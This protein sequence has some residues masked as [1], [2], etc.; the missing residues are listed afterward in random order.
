M[1]EGMTRRE[2]LGA[3]A[4]GAIGLAAGSRLIGSALA[5][6]GELPYWTASKTRVGKVY[7]GGRGGWPSPT[8]DPKDD[9]KWIEG[10]LAKLDP[11][12]ADIE[13]VDGGHVMNPADMAAAKEKFKDVDGILLIPLTMFIMGY[14]KDFLSLDIPTIFFTVPYMGH[15][16]TTFA[17][18]QKQ[19]KRVELLA[20]SDFNAL[21]PAMRPFR[22]IHHLKQA[23]ILDFRNGG[24]LTEYAEGIK[25]RFGTE[26]QFVPR[27]RL[28]EAYKAVDEKLA[29]A[30]A[31][32][33]TKEAEKIVEPTEDDILRGSRLYFAMKKILEEEKA[34]LITIQYCMG[35][36]DLAGAYPCLGFSRLNAE[37]LGG[38]CEGD[39]PSSVT[40]LVFQ[41]LT[42]ERKPGFISDPII[43]TSKGTVIH[44]HCT[45]AVKMDGP[46]G[47]QCPYI[48]R[49]QQEGQRGACLQVKMRVGQEI[50]MAK[51]VD[52]HTMLVSPGEITEIPDVDRACRTKLTTKVKDAQKM[53]DNWHY[54]LHRVVFY[55]DHVDD[56]RRLSRFLGFKV[57]EEGVDEVHPPAEWI[58]RD[59]NIYASYPI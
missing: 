22:A 45:C 59:T 33:W 2:F 13:F 40:Y 5:S 37:G 30:E 47:R 48:I 52:D 15:D 21:I 55:D 10:E 1:K 41:Y 8:I 38:I 11:Q 25:N 57:L 20:T 7:I 43:D 50:T 6:P 39:L 27:E 26:I 14:V 12:L 29:K 3:T 54:G 46:D 53:A 23:R 31:E 28:I 18:L 49:N 9:M 42:P 17:A 51:L 32:R 16:W 4:A 19:G 24:P 56:I 44:A 58:E 35:I 36:P 34:G